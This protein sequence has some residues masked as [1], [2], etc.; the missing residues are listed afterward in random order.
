MLLVQTQKKKEPA[1]IINDGPPLGPDRRRGLFGFPFVGLS[2]RPFGQPSKNVVEG[3]GVHGSPTPRKCSTT[4]AAA[5][6][7]MYR[8]GGSSGRWKRRHSGLSATWPLDYIQLLW[9][10]PKVPVV[11]DSRVSKNNLIHRD[12][13]KSCGSETQK[14]LHSR[15]EKS[16]LK[17]AQSVGHSR[18]RTGRCAR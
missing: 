5:R 6:G 14:P 1:T 2:R 9:G 3:T 18:C 17:L 16:G 7:E 10:G 11:G 12:T 8:S 15:T 4:I 13:N